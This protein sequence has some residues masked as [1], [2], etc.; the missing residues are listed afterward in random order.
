MQISGSS[1]MHRIYQN[2]SQM[3]RLILASLSLAAVAAG[4][5]VL[6]S[7][8]DVMRSGVQP[9][10]TILTPANVSMPA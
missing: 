1:G 4:Q 9:N 6:T 7:R 2:R 8:N 5:D 3:S 10:E